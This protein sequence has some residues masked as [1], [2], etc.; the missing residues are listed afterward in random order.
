MTYKAFLLDIEGTVCPISFVK[1]VLFPYFARQIPDLVQKSDASKSPVIRATLDKFNISDPALLEAHI[2]N[3]VKNDVKDP[4]L[5]ELQGYVWDAGYKSGEIKAPVYQDAIEFIKRSPVVYIYS[6]GSVK[7]Q[8]L[9]FGHVADPRDPSVGID[10]QPYIKGYFDINT[11]GK[12]TED[13]SYTNILK[14]IGLGGDAS[15]VLFLSDNPLELIA[16]EKAGLS[17]GLALREGNAP[18]EN[19]DQYKCYENFDSL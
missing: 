1:D 17:T 15:S 3:L 14:D 4:V 10:M 2:I 7:A 5:K 9:L 18:V 8:K 13:S 11:S 19:K 12:K 6:S 16:A